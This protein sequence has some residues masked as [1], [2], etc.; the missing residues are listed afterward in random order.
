MPYVRKRN[1]VSGTDIKLTSPHGPLS[2]PFTNRPIPRKSIVNSCF[3]RLN[4]TLKR[5]RH[6]IA[7]ALA[8]DR[9]RE[10]R[11]ENP[12]SFSVREAV[13]VA[14]D[15][16]VVGSNV[17]HVTSLSII[18]LTVKKIVVNGARKRFLNLVVTFVT[19]ITS[20]PLGKRNSWVNVRESAVLTRMVMFLCFV[21]LLNRRATYALVTISGTSVSGTDLC[22]FRLVLTI[23]ATFPDVAL[24]KRWHN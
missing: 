1:I 16:T 23:S 9:A 13:D 10:R 8:N 2:M 11:I 3:A 7:P 15:V 20:L 12:L 21:S 5:T 24:P 17:E 4:K 22:P 14:K 19:N 18:I 6:A